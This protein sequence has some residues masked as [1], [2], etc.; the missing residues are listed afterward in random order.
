MTPGIAFMMALGIVF[1]ALV[2]AFLGWILASL[3]IAILEWL[4][5][6]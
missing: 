2:V 6:E 5:L 1:A 4:G 3:V